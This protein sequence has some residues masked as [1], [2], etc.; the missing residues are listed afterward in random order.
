MPLAGRLEAVTATR[1]TMH[2]FAQF[3][4]RS[5]PPLYAAPG[6]WGGEGLYGHSKES[7]TVMSSHNTAAWLWWCVGEERAREGRSGGQKGIV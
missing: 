3:A 6:G 4:V 1:L 7:G 5:V 2:K